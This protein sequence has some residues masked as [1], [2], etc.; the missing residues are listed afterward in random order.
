MTYPLKSRYIGLLLVLTLTLA[1]AFRGGHDG[2]FYVDPVRGNDGNPGNVNKP[3]RSL[4]KALLVVGQRVKRGVRSDKIFL[5][6]GVYRKATDKTSYLLELKG[7][8]DDYSLI[9]AMPCPPGGPGCVQRQSGKW[10]EKVVFDDGQIIRS[11]WTK[12]EGHP[13][14]WATKPGYTL[15][16]WTRQNLWPWRRNGFR[17]ADRDETPETTLFTVA[18]Y[19]LL[20]DGQPTVWEDSHATLTQP[21]SHAYDPA[22]CAKHHVRDI[23]N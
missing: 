23:F 19:M 22:W 1:F 12:V 11:P 10:Y 20:Q 14:I 5:R 7:T 18:P 17:P 16:E 13:G 9:S 8:P 21:G 15:R 3:F 4:D 2:K 6:G